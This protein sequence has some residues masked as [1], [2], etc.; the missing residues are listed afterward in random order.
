MAETHA[1]ISETNDTRRKDH[2]VGKHHV[3]CVV[4]CHSF[5]SPELKRLQHM[6]D[7]VIL[8]NVC[9]VQA[10]SGKLVSFVPILDE[11]GHHVFCT[12]N[13][14]CIAKYC[15]VTCMDRHAIVHKARCSVLNGSVSMPKPKEFAG[16]FAKLKCVNV[17]SSG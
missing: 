1:W 14:R 16:C 13:T 5:E 9:L 10:T 2:S 12:R 3:K 15:S 7:L 17:L 4:E 11:E 6:N 8:S